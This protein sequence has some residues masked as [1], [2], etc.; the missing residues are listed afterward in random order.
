MKDDALDLDDMDMMMVTGLCELQ[1]HYQKQ[2]ITISDAVN[3]FHTRPTKTSAL[4]SL[5]IA[6]ALLAKY[7]TGLDNVTRPGIAKSWQES[8]IDKWRSLP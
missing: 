4:P 2:K 8:L 6:Y 5:S 3:Y 1:R 7:G